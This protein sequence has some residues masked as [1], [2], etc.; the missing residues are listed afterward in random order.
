MQWRVCPP[1]GCD[2]ALLKKMQNSKLQFLENHQP[3]APSK[4]VHAAIVLCIIL[5]RAFGGFM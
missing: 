3:P 1:G 5:C 4:Q 2:L